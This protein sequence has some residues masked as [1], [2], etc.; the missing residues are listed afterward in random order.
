MKK[1]FTLVAL[2]GLG[3]FAAGCGDTAPPAKP[4]PAGPPPGTVMGPPG[5]V[6][7]KEGE[8][9]KEEVAPTEEKKEE[10]A[11]VE[12]KKEEAAPTEEKKE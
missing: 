8:E 3:G 5:G 1:L 7:A 11:P 2:V 12:E 4:S 10:A 9:K 6:P